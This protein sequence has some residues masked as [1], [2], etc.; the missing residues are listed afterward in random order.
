M[1]AVLAS[2]LAAQ[3]LALL[4]ALRLSAHA[5]AVHALRASGACEW[6]R[7]SG[8]GLIAYRSNAHLLSA[9]ALAGAYPVIAQLVGEDN[10]A[11]I[12]RRLWDD[13]PPTRGD[14]AHWG[15]ELA[16]WMERQPQLVREEPYLPDVARVEWALH[17][18]AFAPDAQQDPASFALLASHDP[19]ELALRL[20]PGIALVRSA[21]PVVSI[22][23]AH[24]EHEPALHEAGR[25]LRE[26]VHETAL[27][28]REGLRPRVRLAQGHEAQFIACLQEG[29]SL[30]DSLQAAPQF[31]VAGWL[32]LAAAQGLLLG[33]TAHPESP[34]DTT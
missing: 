16:H 27:I 12:A 15:G 24:L 11:A 28:W 20:C 33:V 25:R 3:Q 6:S 13:H 26:G 9:R 19:V 18:A 7:T 34:G 29:R 30:A 1:T 5:E 21:W 32:H 14:V 31:D 22:V 2:G 23:R 4:Q 10:F 17:R 8:R